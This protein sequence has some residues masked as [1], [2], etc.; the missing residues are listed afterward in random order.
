[1]RNRERQLKSISALVF[2][3]VVLIL[4]RG[5]SV[6]GSIP[7]SYLAQQQEIAIR[8]YCAHWRKT[9]R[10][11]ALEGE[12]VIRVVKDL[13]M[14]YPTAFPACQS[15]DGQPCLEWFNALV[16]GLR[17]YGHTSLRAVCANAGPEDVLPAPD[18]N[19]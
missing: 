1:M 5:I 6:R 2:S 18:F 12:D 16:Q 19:F 7:P 14:L 9:R 8:V 10:E 15:G 3:A 13:E 17:Y 4:M 11:Q